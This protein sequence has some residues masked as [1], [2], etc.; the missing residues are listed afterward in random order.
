MKIASP[1][2]YSLLVLGAALMVGCKGIASSCSKPQA[3][4]TAEALPPLKVPVGLDGPDTRGALV[5][6]D[7]N[8]PEA[9]RG[10]DSACLEE[11]PAF[12]STASAG[13]EAT[14][15]AGGEAPASSRRPGSRSP[16]A[17]R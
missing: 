7:L 17:P 16:R 5:I 15:D 9:P 4:A 12:K 3:Y 6:P 14:D 11:P 10:P 13:T 1:L 2:K 8:E